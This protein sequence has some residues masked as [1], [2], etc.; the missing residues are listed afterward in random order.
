M[1]A[2]PNAKDV[3]GVKDAVESKNDTTSEDV[4]KV[5]LFCNINARTMVKII[6]TYN[7]NN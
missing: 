7:R 1:A 2:D 4:K 6:Q 3:K 5:C